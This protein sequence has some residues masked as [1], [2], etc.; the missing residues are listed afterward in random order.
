MAADLLKL[1]TNAKTRTLVML[2]GGVLIGGIVIA[3]ASSGKT[4][5]PLENRTSKTTQV[6]KGVESIP[7]AKTSE[8]YRELQEKAN[9]IGSETAKRK[10]DT[11]IPTIVANNKTKEEEDLQSRFLKALEKTDSSKLKK[12]DN[13]P[14]VSVNSQ[15]DP[16][17]AQLLA[18]QKQDE[19]AADEYRR[20]QQA[21]LNAERMAAMQEQRLKAIE[22]VAQAMEE[23]TKAAFNAWNDVPVQSYNIGVWELEKQTSDDSDEVDARPVIVKAGTI[24]FG[25]LE[26]SVNSDEP[27]PILAKI[28][29]PP[30][31]DAKLI[32]TMQIP[33]DKAEK[34]TLKFDTLNIPNE[35]LSSKINAVAIDPDTARTALATD[36]N[37]HYLLKWGT[38][39]GSAFLEGYSK[40]VGKS[41]TTSQSVQIP[42]QATT[43]TTNTPN[44]SGRQQ[45]FEGLGEVGS[46]WGEQ[47]KQTSSRSPTIKIASGI[48]IGILILSDVKLGPEPIKK[49]K[50]TAKEENQTNTNA[51]P[52]DL[53]NSIVQKAAQTA[54]TTANQANTTQ[55]TNNTNQQE[56]K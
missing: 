2:A 38:L 42:G 28:I 7:G 8:R 51:N 12:P 11:F 18:Q 31:K 22:T 15:Q 32:G 46:K 14:Q 1:L 33:G 49:V 13:Y 53:L 26:T 5:E 29:Q 50:S 52:L 36:V 23:Q 39:F 35:P 17:L 37:H 43:T 30:F 55:Q 34:I 20:K 10:G 25:I 54:N 21:Q 45:L 24:L 40:A 3:I 16:R 44:L 27:G 19:A 48:G 56:K 9:S 47:L 41:G 4:G 6:P